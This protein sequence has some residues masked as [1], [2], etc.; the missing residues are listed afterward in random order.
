[1]GQSRT[2]TYLGAALDWDAWVEAI[3]KGHSFVT[4]A[5][6]LQLQVEGRI[7]GEDLLLS[8]ASQTVH[9]KGTVESIVP[10]DRVELVV[11]GKRLLVAESSVF[12]RVGAGIRHEFEKSVKIDHSTWITLQAYGNLPVH[13]INDRFPLAATNPVW[14]SVGGKAVRSRES[15][16]YFIRWIDKL[17]TMADS[18]PH[19]RSD[20]EKAHV[21][22]Q[23]RQARQ[24]YLDLENEAT[25]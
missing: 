16:R 11:H 25:E 6:L 24:V 9:I 10:L 2:Y 8:A 4:N 20:R 14:V 13:P 19:W 21:L 7:P 22:G 1:M 15:A 18:H 12:E 23:F 5:P 3:R 17:T